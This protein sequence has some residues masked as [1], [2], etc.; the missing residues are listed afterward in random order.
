MSLAIGK[1][2]TAEQ[3]LRKAT[4]DIIGHPDFVALT[5]V[6]MIGSKKI[7][8]DVP[9][10]CTNGRDEMYGREFVD[11]LSDAEFRFLVLH[12]CY[13]KM[14]KHLTTW[15]HLHKQS[16]QKA[17]MACDYVI[18]LKL[19]ETDA[20]KTG[21]IRLPSGGLIDTKYQGMDS[22]QVFNLLDMDDE[23]EQGGGSGSGVLDDHDWEGASK[24]TEEETKELAQ[25]L[26]QAI[27]QGSILAGKVGSGG[28]RD[29]GELLQTKQDWRELLRDFVTTTCAGKDYSTWKKPNRR[30]IGMD[31][32]M[33]SSI[34]ETVGEIVVGIDTSG[35]IG[36]DE[37]NSFLT[38]IVG[39]CDQVKPSK[40]R[41]MYWDTAVCSE[42]VYLDADYVNLVQST[43]PKGGGGTDPE[44]VPAYMNEHGIKPEAVIM[45]TDG[46]VGSWGNWSVPVMWCILNNKSAHPSVGKAVH[47]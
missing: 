22:Q 15:Q 7:V 42:E 16:A 40:I 1:Q 2:L 13:H 38:E 39:I 3:R 47:I 29:I 44:C 41:L 9:T 19:A 20:G 27:R 4:T 14:Y 8:D 5:G 43:K 23:D 6:L 37:L 34:S 45:L 32:L 18:N 17:N 12:E 46:Y 30:Y 10:A 25:Q 35:S 26:D 36:N 11:N 24:L 33:P 28:N 31:I 21:W